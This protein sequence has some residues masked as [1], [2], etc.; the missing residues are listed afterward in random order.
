MLYSKDSSFV[1]KTRRDMYM[2]SDYKLEPSSSS[3][4]SPE[5]S[6]FSLTYTLFLRLG[7]KFGANSHMFHFFALWIF[8]L[9]A[10]LSTKIVSNILQ[11]K[12]G[13]GTPN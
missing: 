4:L 2:V 1:N 3:S 12:V 5:T 9:N 10:K 13:S 11:V 8:P 7:D 6:A